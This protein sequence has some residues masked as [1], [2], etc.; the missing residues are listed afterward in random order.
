MYLLLLHMSINPSLYL[1]CRLLSLALNSCQHLSSFFIYYFLLMFFYVFRHCCP[2]S[3]HLLNLF[4]RWSFLQ[5]LIFIYLL[6]LLFSSLI[7]NKTNIPLDEFLTAINL[8]INSTY[9]KFNNRYYKQIFGT[10]IGSPLSPIIA[11]IVLQDIENK[12]LKLLTIKPFTYLRFVDDIFIVAPTHYM[13]EIFNT[14]NSLHDRLK[15]HIKLE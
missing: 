7:K 5:L 12:A 13:D 8:V 1:Y 11:D 14:F 15:L 4:S 2:L 3:I 9:F 10:P 6:P